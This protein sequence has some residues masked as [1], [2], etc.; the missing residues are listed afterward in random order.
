VRPPSEVAVGQAAG[1]RAGGDLARDANGTRPLDPNLDAEPAGQLLAALRPRLALVRWVLA[2]LAQLV[3]QQLV[4]DGLVGA[5]EQR[6]AA[7][8][9]LLVQVEPDSTVE[10]GH[11]AEAAAV[12]GQRHAPA[13]RRD[14]RQPDNGQDEARPHQAI[15]E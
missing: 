7:A 10:V 9:E 8:E 3:V 5:I 12:A 14:G 6:G 11:M 4:Q 15:A 13:V 2:E 1:R